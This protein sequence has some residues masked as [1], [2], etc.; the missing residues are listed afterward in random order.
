MENVPESTLQPRLALYYPYIHIRS[1]HWLKGT[2][3]CTPA[4]KRIVPEK[5]TP[6][7][8][9]TILKFT[10]IKGASGALLQTVPAVSPAADLAQEGLLTRI[11]G[12][13]AAIRA[14]FDRSQSPVPDEYWIHDAKF[15]GNLLAY[16]IA[17]DLAW[18]SPHSKGYGHRNWYA[19]HPMLGSAIMTTLGLSIANE[20]HY[21]IVTDS[22]DFHEKLLTTSQDEVF[23]RILQ[24]S[25]DASDAAVTKRQARRD[26]GQMIITLAGINF[27]ALQPEDIPELQETK[28]FEEFRNLIRVKSQTIDGE[29]EP[30]EYK[31]Q[32][33][34]EAKEIVDAW[35]GAKSGV[36][37]GL[38][39]V[40]F[41]QGLGHSADALRKYVSHQAWDG[42]GAVIA[43]GI[44]VGC[45]AFKEW[46]KRRQL[47]N[48]PYQYLTKITEAEDRFLQMVFPLGLDRS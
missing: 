3:L 18:S 14:K 1:E 12:N 25:A 10:N 48:S 7:D 41:A 8:L 42:G 40:L 26:L 4:V 17:E 20:Q 33:T 37:Q 27:E 44:A 9:P 36:R 38:R 11:R 24:T 15:N 34:R 28:A 46:H 45:L 16:L 2:L 35:N 19:M 21:D 5:Y 29:A 22:T 47:Q 23:E 31:D 39:D 32:I 6:E 13:V 43:T 30:D